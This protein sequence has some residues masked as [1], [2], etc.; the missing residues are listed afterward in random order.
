MKTPPRLSR[1]FRSYLIALHIPVTVRR[2]FSEWAAKRLPLCG[3]DLLPGQETNLRR[4]SLS[5]TDGRPEPA[6]CGTDKCR[7]SI[8]SFT[9]LF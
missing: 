3:P 5:H 2:I 1:F 9:F 7:A 8:I 6:L 4:Q